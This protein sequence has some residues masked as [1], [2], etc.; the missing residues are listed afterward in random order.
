QVLLFEELNHRVK[1]TLATIQAIASQ[2]LRRAADPRD[3]VKSFNGRVQALARA[4]D[5]LVQGRM[6]GAPIGE[7]LREQVF[8]GGANDGRIHCAGPFMM[9]DARNA[10]QLALVM[11]ELATN[12]RK[13]GA[14]SLPEGRLSIEWSILTE[15]ER[16]LRIMWKESGVENV[17]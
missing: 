10:V 16:M 13:Y 17:S 12:A 6:K 15:P 3:F 2:S 14:L 5:L 4:H 7:T 9:L 11:H 8:F 1:N